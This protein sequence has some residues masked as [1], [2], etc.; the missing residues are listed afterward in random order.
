[1][2]REGEGGKLL[3]VLLRIKNLAKIGKVRDCDVY[4]MVDT[5]AG[6]AE[7]TIPASKGRE[8]GLEALSVMSVKGFGCQTGVPMLVLSSLRTSIRL[9][10]P[11]TGDETLKVNVTP[12]MAY[13]CS[14][15]TRTTCMAV[16]H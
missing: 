1:M 11:Q 7:L 8:L 13:Y 6:A 3:Y 10:D 4:A 16:H 5:G 12:C 15:L 9:V 2:R 14:V